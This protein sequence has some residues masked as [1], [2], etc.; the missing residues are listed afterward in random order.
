MCDVITERLQSIPFE[1]KLNNVGYRLKSFKY[2]IRYHI[3][4]CFFET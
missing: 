3:T 2:H 4:F 1:L